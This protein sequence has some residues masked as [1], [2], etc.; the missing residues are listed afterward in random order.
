ML[1]PILVALML[2]VTLGGTPAV[3]QGYYDPGSERER[4]RNDRYLDR[5]AWE[6]EQ[7]FQRQQQGAQ[8][9]RIEWGHQQRSTRDRDFYNSRPSG[10]FQHDNWWER[11]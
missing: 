3:A 11:R 6:R 5:K 10:N 7:G 9:D 8:R 1:K 4:E 2:S